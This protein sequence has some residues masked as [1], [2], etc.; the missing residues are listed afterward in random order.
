MSHIVLKQLNFEHN[1][2]DFGSAPET[3]YSDMNGYG[4]F[5]AGHTVVLTPTGRVCA[6][7]LLVLAALYWARG[8]GTGLARAQRVSPVR[9]SARRRADCAG[10]VAAAR[11]RSLG[12][13]IFYNTNVLNR[14]V[15]E[16]IWRRS[17]KPT[18]KRRYGE[19]QG[20]TTTAH[21]RLRESTSI[22]T[23]PSARS[24]CAAIT[25]WSTRPTAPIR[26]LHVSYCRWRWS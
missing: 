15:P 13:W 24:T 12:A 11:S 17:A 22:S 6:I 26:D 10:P 25:G 23:P 3:P 8:T 20:S 9:G 1:L 21:R 2:Y 14:Y 18:T 4:H 7:A 19:L 5:L 16:Q